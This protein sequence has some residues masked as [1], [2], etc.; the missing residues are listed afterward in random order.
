[1]TVLSESP[2]YAPELADLMEHEKVIEQGLA[3]FIEVGNALLAIKADRK[4]R[5]AGY[6]TFEA[7]CQERWGISRAYGNR[8]V[9]AA[10]IVD[11]ITKGL[12][13]APEPESPIVKDLAPIGA[14]PLP[15]TASQ[16]RPLTALPT[17]LQ[18]EAW[19]EAVVEAGGN[20]PTASQVT[21]A[22]ERRKPMPVPKPAPKVNGER[23]EEA[24]PHPAV[25][26]DAVLDAFR[27]LLAEHCDEAGLLVDPFAGTG[28]VH[29]LQADGWDTIGVELEPEW[30]NLHPDTIHGDSR[31]L[32]DVVYDATQAEVVDVI[33][34]SPAYGNRLADYYAASDPEARRSYGIDL[35]RRLSEGN[36]A[37]LQWGTD[38]QSLHEKV[39]GQAVDLLAPGGLFLLNCKNHRRDGKVQ[40]VIAWHIRSLVDLGLQVVDE[41]ELVP[42]GLANT[43]AAKLPERVIAFRKRSS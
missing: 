10:S 20:Q 38:Y 17:E 5:H 22:V 32:C 15:E 43:T 14:I 35:G 11:T 6:S 19:V 27:E 7:Y 30:A 29:E 40:Q 23:V 34:T 33:A 36:G 41:R 39:W 28:R 16:V 37:A 12:H 13:A 26:S 3:G 4:Y 25:Y 21:E 9:L 1:M 2:K 42:A 8:L 24:P 31:N 18:A